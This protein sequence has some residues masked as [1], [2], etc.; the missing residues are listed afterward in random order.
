[1]EENLV[2]ARLPHRVPEPVP[3]GA[4]HGLGLASTIGLDGRL[5]Q[6]AGRCYELTW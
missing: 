2:A 1:M 5:R 4:G 6:K 3:G